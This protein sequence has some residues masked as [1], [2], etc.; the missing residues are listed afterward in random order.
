[1]KMY[2]EWLF[3][4]KHRGVDEIL[5]PIPEKDI[6]DHLKNL[7]FLSKKINLVIDMY[8]VNV[9]HYKGSEYIR[10]LS[11]LLDEYTKEICLLMTVKDN[12]LLKN[13]DFRK[14]F[15]TL[16]NHY[17]DWH[18]L[19]GDKLLDSFTKNMGYINYIYDEYFNGDVVLYFH[20]AGKKY[21]IRDKIMD[22]KNR[23]KHIEDDPFSEEVWN[24]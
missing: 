22:E 19:K 15:E 24:Q 4:R 3:S 2:E 20:D 10:K 5:Y 16:V 11:S 7:K 12:D 17:K 8:K 18:I 6:E 9:S 23:E 1:M 21:D 14:K 13:V